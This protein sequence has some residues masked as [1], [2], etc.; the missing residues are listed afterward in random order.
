[1]LCLEKKIKEEKFLTPFSGTD[2]NVSEKQRFA[3]IS[4]PFDASFF[5]VHIGLPQHYNDAYGIRRREKKMRIIFASRLRQS[6][7]GTKEMRKFVEINEKHGL[8]CS[9]CNG[10]C[11]SNSK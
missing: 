10:L 2:K 3:C 9:I 4:T 8:V 1:M 6:E 5:P 7:R 11:F